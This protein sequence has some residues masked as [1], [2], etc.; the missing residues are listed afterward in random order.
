[1]KRCN[2]FKQQLIPIQ[3]FSLWM[4]ALVKLATTRH[5]PLTKLSGL[6]LS[7]SPSST[8]MPREEEPYQL[9]LLPVV[10]SY[11]SEQESILTN[12]SLLSPVV[13]SKGFLDSAI[14]KVWLRLSRRQSPRRSRKSWLKVSR[15]ES[16][17]L[18]T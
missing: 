15:K 14:F 10:L 5:R 11:S 2:K 13:S 18:E 7:L 12:S 8:V 3:H 1:M 16:S 6:V 4:E 17:P 9:W